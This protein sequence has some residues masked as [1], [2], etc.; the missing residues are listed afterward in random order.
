MKDKRKKS[1]HSHVSQAETKKISRGVFFH[2]PVA[3]LLIE[4]PRLEMAV[5]RMRIMRF[6]CEGTCI[7]TL[8]TKRMMARE[9]DILRMSARM[10]PA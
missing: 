9:P 5:R 6:F 3:I 8:G 7:I 4:K 2:A 1:K 10:T